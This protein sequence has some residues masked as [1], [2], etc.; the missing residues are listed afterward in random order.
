MLDTRI[1]L[2]CLNTDINNWKTEL[3][4]QA[5]KNIVM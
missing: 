3:T 5:S 1:L 4:K 2:I